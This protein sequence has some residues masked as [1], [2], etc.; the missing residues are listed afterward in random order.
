MAWKASVVAELAEV[1]IN[2]PVNAEYR[3]LVARC[4]DTA[5]A[6]APGQFFQLLCP[7]PTGEQPFLRRPGS[8][9]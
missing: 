5:A 9:P 1:I 2:D 7:Q 6:A 4:S 8:A 3:H